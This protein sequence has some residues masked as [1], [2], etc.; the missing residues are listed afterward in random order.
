MKLEAAVRHF[1]YLLSRWD[2]E[3][4]YESWAE[5]Q[6]AMRRFLAQAG[7]ELV[8]M[9]EERLQYKDNGKLVEVLVREGLLFPSVKTL[10]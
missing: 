1:D 6:D 5:Y 3:R 9:T 7:C 8:Q 4:E 10:Q 2:D